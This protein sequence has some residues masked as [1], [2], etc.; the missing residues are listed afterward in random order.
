MGANNME[1]YKSPLDQVNAIAPESTRS[2]WNRYF[3]H[4]GDGNPR[5]V[6]KY[7]RLIEEIESE[8]PFENDDEHKKWLDLG[9]SWKGEPEWLDLTENLLQRGEAQPLNYGASDIDEILKNNPYAKDLDWGTSMDYLSEKLGV[10]IPENV[11]QIYR[12][13]NYIYGV[14]G[15]PEGEPIDKVLY[16]LGGH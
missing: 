3:K 9:A 16:K 6:D 2:K 4:I 7:N 1:I 12:K 15:Q 8:M 5:T 11:S 10:K 14:E 13:N